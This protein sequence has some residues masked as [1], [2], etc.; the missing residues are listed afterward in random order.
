MVREVV[1]RSGPVTGGGVQAQPLTVR[2]PSPCPSTFTVTGLPK[3]T[4]RTWGCGGIWGQSKEQGMPTPRVYLR[5][6]LRVLP[7]SPNLIPICPSCLHVSPLYSMSPCVPPMSP[8][9]PMSFMTP[10]VPQTRS[11]YVPH[12]C[13]SPHVF[14]YGPHIPS[15]PCP[16]CPV[17]IYVPPSHTPEVP[18]PAAPGQ[19]PVSLG[20]PQD[21]LGSPPARTA[22]G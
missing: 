14:Q 18:A 1:S 20:C 12:V 8:C 17:P 6:P 4:W 15:V 9:L 10:Y 21:L 5:L 16:P 7:C 2:V 3:G 22:P 19:A 13:T 11:S